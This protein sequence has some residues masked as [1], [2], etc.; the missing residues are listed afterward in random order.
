MK[1]SLYFEEFSPVNF[2]NCF[3]GFC[4]PQLHRLTI[5]L[6]WIL[7]TYKPHQVIW[8]CAI[9]IFTFV[10][11]VSWNLNQ[12]KLKNKKTFSFLCFNHIDI[13]K[14][15]YFFER[16]F[17]IWNVEIHHFLHVFIWLCSIFSLFNTNWLN[18][19]VKD[20]C[21]KCVVTTHVCITWNGRVHMSWETIQIG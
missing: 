11:G 4:L 9:S 1:N 3:S 16:S 19:S 17:G 13:P 18:G 20:L 12:E 7:I 6:N 15:Q 10:K 5:I 21:T 14:I 8:Y 2:Y